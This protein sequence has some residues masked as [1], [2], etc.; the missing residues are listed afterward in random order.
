MNLFAHCRHQIKTTAVLIVMNVWYN[1]GAK[2]SLPGGRL[3]EIISANR[4]G[5]RLVTERG[6]GRQ[7]DT[8]IR[9]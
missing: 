2:F 6:E 5:V 3:G 1:E 8:R 9:M 7:R 4:G